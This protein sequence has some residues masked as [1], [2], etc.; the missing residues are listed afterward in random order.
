MDIN[1]KYFGKL[2]DVSGTD[3]ETVVAK[4]G[5]SVGELEQF[6]INKYKVLLDETY[7]LFKN[8]LKVDDKTNPIQHNDELSFMPPFSGG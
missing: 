6:L 1:V 8:N 3:K 4:E 5:L 2:T 7:I